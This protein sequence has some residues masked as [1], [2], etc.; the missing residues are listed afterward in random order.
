MNVAYRDLREFIGLVDDIG[1][2]R[3]VSGASLMHEIGAI[4]EVAAGD[5]SCP[6]LLFNDI[7][8]QATGNRVFTN[9]TVSARRAALAL[10]IDY[11]LP[12]LEALKLWKTRRTSLEPIA[13]VETKDIPVLENEARGQDVDLSRFP[14]PVWHKLDGGPYIGSGSVVLTQDPDTG[15]V[16]C[17]I[18]RVQVHSRNRVTIQFDHNGRHGAIIS[19]KYW[20]RGQACPVA[21]V[22]GQDPSLFIAGF[23]YLPEGASELDFAGAIRGAPV[24]VFKGPLTGLPIPA[25]AEIVLEGR[26]LPMAV[27]SLPEGPFGEFTGYYAADSRPGPVMEVDATYFRN[28]PILFGSPPLKP[29]RFHFGLSFRAASIWSNLEAAGVTDVVGAWQH[30]SQLMTVVAIRQR[31]AGHAKRA[32]LIAAAHSYMGRLVVV[33]DEDIDPT[34]LNDVMWAITTR[35]EPSEDVDI[36]RNAWSSS[37]DPRIPPAHRDIGLTSHSK[38]IIDACIPF[39]QLGTYAPTTALGIQEAQGIRQKWPQVFK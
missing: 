26:L 24:E 12:A 8:G 25:R 22:N 10:G 21:V 1:D 2:L 6:A 29:P 38:M 31:Y 5:A 15:W 37:L 23:E 19:K 4:T 32:A 27:E 36:I 18:Y 14:S 11:N 13:P 16:N 30:V 3:R 34:S 28:D 17:S 35:A 7:P 33:V 39:Q 9:A 20:D